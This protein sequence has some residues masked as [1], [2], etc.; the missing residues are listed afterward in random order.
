VS[1]SST[2]NRST[3]TV[4]TVC[5]VSDYENTAITYFETVGDKFT[6]VCHSGSGVCNYHQMDCEVSS[7]DV[8]RGS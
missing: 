1:S 8:I 2:S 6:C 5:W 7:F 4:E 3:I